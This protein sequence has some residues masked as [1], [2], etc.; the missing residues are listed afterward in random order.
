MRLV[1]IWTIFFAYIAIILYIVFQTEDDFGNNIFSDVQ[2]ADSLLAD[3]SLIG[4]PMTQAD[5]LFSLIEDAL[6]KGDL[7]R[8]RELAK[9]LE[10]KYPGST[11]SQA[12]QILIENAETHGGDLANRPASGNDGQQPKVTPQTPPP[13]TKPR[14]T[15]RRSTPRNE[16]RLAQERLLAKNQQ[17]LDEALTRMRSVRSETQNITWYYNKNVSHYVYKNS[18]EAYIGQ[19]DEGDLWLRLR[20]YYN[21]ENGL[22]IHTYG[23]YVDDKEYTISTLN[24]K[25][26]RGRGPKGAYEWF[27]KYVSAKEIEMLQEIMNAKRAALRYMGKTEN[28][29]R[30]LTEMEKLRIKYVMEAYQAMLLP[31]KSNQS[32]AALKK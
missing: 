5:S 16:E 9:L 28:W 32:I 27:D 14:A 15:T 21:G 18:F 2:V 25:M 17:I 7:D 13:N 26:E 10:E 12:A 8:A 31:R 30:T 24:G 11:N 23:V 6:E 20:I 19:S 1:V 22:N 4:A 3:S 29:E